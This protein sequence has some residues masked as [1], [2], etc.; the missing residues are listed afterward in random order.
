MNRMVT[1]PAIC[2][3]IAFGAFYVGRSGM[4]GS[5][6]S[7]SAAP[8]SSADFGRPLA[9]AD[10]AEHMVRALGDQYQE[11]YRSW[12][13]SPHKI[14]SRVYLGPSNL[15]PIHVEIAMSPQSPKPESNLASA[16]IS[17]RQKEATVVL[18]CVVDVAT[19]EILVFQ[20]GRWFSADEWL[21]TAGKNNYQS[22]SQLLKK[23]G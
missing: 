22:R 3:L 8:I 18:P 9:S 4:F 16:T 7:A 1:L 12:E 17:I 5:G 2:S 14:M 21:D 20:S 23:Q 10:D 6:D 13:T 11:R 15:P 19:R